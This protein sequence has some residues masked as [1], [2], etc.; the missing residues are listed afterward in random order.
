MI[1]VL[2][3][4][5]AVLAAVIWA[6]TAVDVFRRHYSLWPTVGWLVLITVLPLLGSLLYW[7]LRKPSAEEVE[8]QRLAQADIRHEA[9]ARS[10]DSTRTQL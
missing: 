7:T 3:W 9:A 6:I 8:R 4:I 5:V 1:G 10:V 2:L